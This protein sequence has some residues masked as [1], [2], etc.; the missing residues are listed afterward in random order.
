MTTGEMLKG[1]SSMLITTS[2]PGNS[3]RDIRMALVT[4]K[5]VLMGTATAD[6]SN[7]IFT[8][9]RRGYKLY[10]YHTCVTFTGAWYMPLLDMTATPD[11]SAS[12]SQSFCAQTRGTV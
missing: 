3:F 7:V 11:N 1:R 4:P 5:T 6:S 2:F 12:C 10:V 8:C 9:I